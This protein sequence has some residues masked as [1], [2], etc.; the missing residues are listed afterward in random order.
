MGFP[1]LYSFSSLNVVIS[2][3]FH[4]SLLALFLCNS[5]IILLNGKVCKK[6]NLNILNNS[7]KNIKK[8]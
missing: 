8:K 6:R 3:L 1:L 4:M 2:M 5:F 7:M